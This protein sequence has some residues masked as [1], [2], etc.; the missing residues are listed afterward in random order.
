MRKSLI[1][2]SLLLV[3][4]ICVWAGGKAP[5]E[6]KKSTTPIGSPFLR[7]FAYDYN[8]DLKRLVQYEKRGFG[9]T[10]IISLAL[11]SSYTGKKM[12]VYGK[13]RLKQKGTIRKY[14][15]EAG[16]DY[17]EFYKVVREIKAEIEAKGDKDLP[18]PVFGEIKPEKEEDKKNNT[19]EE[20]K[21]I[22]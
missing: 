20:E 16:L 12:K 9:R 18:P 7:H 15:E 6:V 2:L 5:P 10:E 8:Y 19:L 3:T 17:D 4:P 13:K 21:T 14:V 1:I 22:P 11:L